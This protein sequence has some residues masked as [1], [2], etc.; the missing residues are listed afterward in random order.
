MGNFAL[1]VD[2]AALDRGHGTSRRGKHGGGGLVTDGW[3]K[4]TIEDPKSKIP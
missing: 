4:S 1:D 2:V 3:T